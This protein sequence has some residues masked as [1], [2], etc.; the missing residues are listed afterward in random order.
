MRDR[1]CHNNAVRAFKKETSPLAHLGRLV[2][3]LHKSFMLADSAVQSA[4]KQIPS[5][6]DPMFS[7]SNVSLS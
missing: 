1:G 5:K 7:D 6:H 2:A 3:T 4:I